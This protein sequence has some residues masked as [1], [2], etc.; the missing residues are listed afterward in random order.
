[1]GQLPETQAAESEIPVE[2]ATST[3]IPAAVPE[4][5]RELQAFTHFGDGRNS[6]HKFSFTWRWAPR[7]LGSVNR[8]E[9]APFELRRPSP[10]P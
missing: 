4:A 8:F 1:M 7:A 10:Q 9:V 2:R 3:A 6:S 5:R